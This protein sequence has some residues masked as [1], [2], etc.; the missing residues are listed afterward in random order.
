MLKGLGL[1]KVL[2]VSE[3]DWHNEHF[4]MDRL[5]G[6]SGALDRSYFYFASLQTPNLL[7]LIRLHDIKTIIGMGEPVMRQLLGERDLLRQR[8]RVHEWMGRYFLPTFAPHKLIAENPN[9]KEVAMLKAQGISALLR[10]PRFQGTWVLDVAFG[11]HIARHG[12]KRK[13]PNYTVDPDPTEFAKWAEGYERALA[14]DSDIY[15]SWDIETPY[16]QK[17]KNEDE[18]EEADFDK[19]ILRV[20]F[21]YE[22]YTGVSVPWSPGYLGT[23]QRLLA[24]AGPKVVWNG[25]TFDIPVVESVGVYVNG[26][27]H[28]Y[29]DGWHIYQSDLPKGL[30]FVTSFTSDL[31]PWK[32]LNNSDPGI[33]SAI[34][35]DAALRNA[36][37]IRAKLKANGQ[38]PTFMNH[39]VRLMPVMRQAGKRGNFIDIQVRDEL[40][41][42]MTALLEQKAAEMQLYV[43]RE[44]K[45]RKVWL[46]PRAEDWE[47]FHDPKSSEPPIISSFM[48]EGRDFDKVPAEAELKVCTACGNI[49]TNKSE[50]YANLKGA[51]KVDKHGV[52][53][54]GK[55]GNPLFESI[56]NPCKEA[57]GEIQ[58]RQGFRYEYHEVE[59]FNPNSSTQLKVYARYYGHPIGENKQDSDKESMDA[60]HLKTL[61]KA[62]GKKHPLYADTLEYHKLSKTLGTYVYDPDEEGLIH[63]TYKNTPST[64]RFSSANVNLQNVGKRD[65]N[66][67]AKK[68]RKQIKARDGYRFVQSDSSAIEALVQGWWMGDPVYMELATQSVHAWVVAKK[69]GLEWTGTEEQVSYLKEHHKDLYDKMKT[70]NYLTNFGGGDYLLWKSFPEQFPTRKDAKD[71]QQML[72]DML[73]KLPEF[74]HWVR[75]KAHKE[76]YLE[77]PG[78][79]HR[80]YFYDVYRGIDERT[81]QPKM[82]K[83]AKRVCAFFPQGCAASFMRD[84]LLLLAFGDAAA[85]WLNI[86][87]LGLT[88]GWLEYMP[89][90]LVVHDGYTLEVPDGLE[91]DAANDMEK[92]LT[93]PISQ[94]AGLRVGCETD[95]SEVGGNWAPYH[96]TKNPEGLKTVKTVRV[97]VVPPP[98]DYR[99]AA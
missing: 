65:D 84:N 86:E 70:T 2:L 4:M 75:T 13:V 81:G 55:S 95:I 20:S 44:A 87:P 79:K 18:F 6:R 48:F 77:L 25:T 45:P 32:H 90:N 51:Q 12:F 60:G 73:P 22:E 83:D 72:F 23:I 61:V 59:D 33:Y 38:W 91:W 74:H 62:Y 96:E 98:M 1:R 27:I 85:E 92:V 78:W 11:L 46:T 30:E 50:H 37:W 9:D 41:R 66:P 88:R 40:R 28:D 89:A 82:A 53:R 42:D 7:E 64:P 71:A 49:A 35:A 69:L 34:D 31:L 56:K 57:G 99:I 67:W 21:A 68:A 36:N 24:S 15:L 14:A 94:L 19:T 3:K 63:T 16:K 93:R 43:P 80:H 8:G 26:E 29:M 54:V 47:R 52:P 76:A 58:T 10:P 97:P 39:V 5:I 17:N